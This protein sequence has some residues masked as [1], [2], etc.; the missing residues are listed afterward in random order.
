MEEGPNG[1]RK[2][3]MIGWIQTEHLLANYVPRDAMRTLHLPREEE[4]SGKGT[5]TSL[6]CPVLSVLFQQEL[7][8]GDAL[9]NWS[10]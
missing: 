6:R 8:V 9:Q 7:E 10:P 5:A 1:H 2:V 3:G 4:N